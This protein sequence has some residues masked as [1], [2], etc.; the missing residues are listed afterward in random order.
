MDEALSSDASCISC[1]YE[2]RA[3]RFAGDT[4][5]TWLWR[6]EAWRP[7]IGEQMSHNLNV[8]HVHLSAQVRCDFPGA[9]HCSLARTSQRIQ[10]LKDA[11]L[12]SN[13]RVCGSG[14][15]HVSTP[16]R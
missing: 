13:S 5:S 8:D 7:N 9:S 4:T 6:L 15:K 14:S 10:D 12:S 11:Y 2:V 16:V 3:R 1:R